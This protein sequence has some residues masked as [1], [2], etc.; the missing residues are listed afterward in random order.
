MIVNIQE[1]YEDI[2]SAHWQKAIQLNE[3]VKTDTG[4]KLRANSITERAKELH[5]I[6]D[7]KAAMQLLFE[8]D[9]I[10]PE[11]YVEMCEKLG[12]TNV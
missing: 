10:I 4:S 5:R 2:L 1:L 6:K 9:L 12:I 11:W 7:K 8:D 3:L